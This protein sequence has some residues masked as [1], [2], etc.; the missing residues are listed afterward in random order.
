MA[1]QIQKLPKSFRFKVAKGKKMFEWKVGNHMIGQ[2]H[3]GPSTS[4]QCKNIP[5]HAHLRE[6][7]VKWLKAGLIELVEA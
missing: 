2:Y 5:A 4:Y 6:Q 1:K 3:E 7:C